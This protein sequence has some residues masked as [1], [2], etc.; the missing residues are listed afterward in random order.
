[1]H[2]CASPAR[3]SPPSSRS[4]WPLALVLPA[5]A[6]GAA[7][8]VGAHDVDPGAKNSLSRDVAGSATAPRHHDLGAGQRLPGRRRDPAGRAPADAGQR[9]RHDGQARH[10]ADR[11]LQHVQQLLRPAVHPHRPVA[12]RCEPRL[13]G[14]LAGRRVPAVLQAHH[15]GS[16]PAVQ[17][18]P[19]VPGLLPAAAHLRL[20]RRPDLGLGGDGVLDLRAVP[21]LR[22]EPGLPHRRHRRPGLDRGHRHPAAAA[23][24]H[25][26]RGLPRDRHRRRRQPVLRRLHDA[27]GARLRRRPHPRD[28]L[29]VPRRRRALR[30]AVVAVRRDRG[31]ARLPRPRAHRRQGGRRWRPSCPA[32]PP[33]TRSAGRP[34]RTGRPRTR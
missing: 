5:G 3:V 2:G 14:P 20:G 12:D 6:W 25:R 16:L 21:L 11:P 19:P 18:G 24:A 26:L 17:P 1:M 33:T 23:A 31:A 29:R 10:V 7:G 8:P 22:A 27:G 34:S 30:P 13:H 32:S 4:P 28:G 9:A 15:A